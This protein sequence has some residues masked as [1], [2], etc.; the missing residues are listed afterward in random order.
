MDAIIQCLAAFIGCLGFTF[1]FRIYKNIRFSVIGSLIG[2]IGWIIYLSTDFLDNIYL[3]SFLAMLGVGLLAELM[4]RLYKTPATIFIII[5]CFPLVPGSGI[6]YTMLYA[7]QGFNDLFM[8]SMLSTLGISMS[9]A[10]AILISSS[11]LQIYKRIKN[12]DYMKIE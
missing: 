10:L 6:Y 5:G 12:K 3:Q 8:S 2:T 1:I 11:I 9:L 7:V 4:A